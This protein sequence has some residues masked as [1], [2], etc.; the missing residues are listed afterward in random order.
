MDSILLVGAGRMGGAMLRGWISA[1]GSGYHFVA[2]DPHAGPSLA[3]IGN[4]PVPGSRFTYVAQI[5][6]LPPNLHPKVVVLATKPQQVNQAITDLGDCIVSDTVVV[7]VAAGVS[8]QSISGAAFTDAAIVRVM[9]NI[10][11]LVGSA[12]SAGFALPETLPHQKALVEELFA[13]VGQ[14]IWLDREEDMH[15][16]TAVSGSGPAYYFAFCEAMIAAAETEG[17]P[18]DIARALAIGTVTSA[19]Q[20][21][22][23]KPDPTHLRETVTSPNGTTAAG[24]G[25]LLSNGE[26]KRLSH[27]AVRAAAMRSRELS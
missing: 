14:M 27:D 22:T 10:G 9:P 13:S 7:S 20:L 12:V 15:L 18:S 1:M 4:E 23:R 8:T 17:L 16:A 11:A 19:G 25:A 21:L 24:L 26:L 3:D 5:K 2:L 6:D